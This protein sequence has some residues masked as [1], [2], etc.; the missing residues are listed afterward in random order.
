M[1]TWHFPQ[2]FATFN[3]LIGE[4]RSTARLMSCTP[5]QSLHEGA[6]I[7]PIFSSARP[8]MLSMYWEAASGYFIWYSFV[9]PG[10]L[11]Q[12]AQVLGRLSLKTGE[13]ECFAGKM[14]WDPWQSLQPAAP[15]APRLWL[16]PWMLMA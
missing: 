7:N 14:L 6:T 15:E 13:S 10:L 4:S 3:G 16:A 2:V 9:S 5:W 11:W 8:W 12:V 1:R